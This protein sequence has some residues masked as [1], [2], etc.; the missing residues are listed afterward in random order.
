MTKWKREH[1]YPEGK[2]EREAA[3]DF[4]R[5]SKITDAKIA[6]MTFVPIEEVREMRAYFETQGTERAAPKIN[7]IVLVA[8]Q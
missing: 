8:R 7:E 6:R 5:Y 3:R 2:P 1:Y 4:V